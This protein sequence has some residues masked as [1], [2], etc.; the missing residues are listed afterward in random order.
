MKA[1]GRAFLFYSTD[2]RDQ[3][4]RY[5]IATISQSEQLKK[6]FWFFN[7]SNKS[8]YIPRRV[9][10]INQLPIIISNGADKAIVG[11]NVV[12]WLKSQTK[13][14]EN[15]GKDELTFVD[16]NKSGSSIY[17]EI[18]EEF[19]TQKTA[20]QLTGDDESSLFSYAGV[21][22]QV[23]INPQEE[24]LMKKDLGDIA[25]QRFNTMKSMRE[26]E[27][28]MPM[29]LHDPTSIDDRDYERFAS[30][31]QTGGP[32]GQPT[33]YGQ[34]RQMMP[35]G[36]QMPH[37]QPYPQ[38]SRQQQ[39]LDPRMMASQMPRM[40]PSY[41]PLHQDRIGERQMMAPMYNSGFP[42]MEDLTRGAVDTRSVMN[43]QRE[44]DKYS[45]PYA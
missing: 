19:G 38:Q 11:M 5:T 40:Q 41:Q 45:K 15:G 10:E 33:G 24:R 37:M 3:I 20:Y 16:L 34:Q 7:V 31:P 8:V 2:P 14:I 18:K 42:Q 23:R 30:Q 21:D 1:S 4:S 27:V 6:M 32:M 36:Q 13:M 26:Q 44:M 9:R 25:N 39:M 22:E 12:R 17:E 29:N 28:K 35:N 43:A